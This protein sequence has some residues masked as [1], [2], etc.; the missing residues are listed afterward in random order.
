ML[1]SSIP[2]K[3]PIPWANSAGAGYVRTIPEASQIGITNGAASLTDGFPPLNFIQESA[4]GVPP[5]GQD[6]NGILKQITQWLQWSQAGAPVVYDATFSSAIGGYPKGAV[7]QSA[8][9]G[10]WWLSTADNN[11]SDP[12]MGGANW[13]L[14]GYGLVYAG[15]P[16]GYVAG[17]AVASGGLAAS[18]L[19]DTVHDAVWFCTTTGTALTAVWVSPTQAS[20]IGLQSVTATVASSAVIATFNG[21]QLTF[22]SATLT[23]GV[24]V[25][26]NVGILTC[27]IPSGATLG[28]TNGVAAQIAMLVAYNGGTE[29]LCVA[30][31]DGGINLDE[32]TLISPTAISSSSNSASVIYSASTVS[33]GSPFRVVGY[34]NITEA[35]AGTWVT[36]PTEVQGLGGLSGIVPLLSP[37]GISTLASAS[38]VDLGS[39]STNAITITGTTTIASFGSSA[40]AGRIFFVTFSGALTLTYNATSLLLPSAQSI[41]TVAGDTAIVQ[42]LGSSNFSVLSYNP[43]SG[44]SVASLGFNQTYQNVTS[45]RSLN[46]TYYN[47]TDKPILLMWTPQAGYSSSLTV[48]GVATGLE[49]SGQSG[50]QPTSTFII[51]PGFSYAQTGTLSSYWWEFR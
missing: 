49:A 41:T 43:I 20:V 9:G 13:T 39:I 12:D 6:E 51:P 25:N 10:T 2:S 8:V 46:T 26:V 28:T 35:T 7:L 15:N 31:M 40:K 30:N 19:W 45:S 14:L 24:P 29:V 33:A 48:N 38:T 1:A 4:G 34:F 32:T 21:G 22:R 3:F 16:N 44:A 11:A 17:V 18:M 42:A 27:I 37:I 50:V 5:F 36:A 23:T 47:T